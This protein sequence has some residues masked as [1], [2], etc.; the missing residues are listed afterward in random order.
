LLDRLAPSFERRRA[1]LDAS[2]VLFWL[3]GFARTAAEW[4]ETYRQL[5]M[6]IDTAEELGDVA[7]WAH[8]A[9]RKGF[10][11]PDEALLRRSVE[12]AR[13]AGHAGV[14][15][16]TRWN[17]G[18]YLGQQ[19]RYEQALPLIVEAI[20][21]LEA[22][23]T[24][25]DHTWIMAM[26]GRCHSAR[27]G[28]M[29]QALAYATRARAAT[30]AM[31]DPRLRAWCGMEAEPYMYQGRWE[32]VVRVGEEGLRAAWEI[33][34]WA[35]IYFLSAWTGLAYL[36]LG[37]LE[38][39]RRVVSRALRE[40]SA[41]MTPPFIITFL[42]VTLAQ[43]HLQAG[44]H[45]TALAAARRAL[46]LADQS[47][48]RLE[49]GAARRVLGTV[50]AA[51]GHREEADW[52]LRASLEILDEIQCRPELAQTLLAYGRFKVANDTAGGKAMIE[53]AL[54]LFEEMRATGW[55]D[56]TRAALAP[57]PYAPS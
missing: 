41:R 3:P 26:S 50:L 18:E 39:A 46:E 56:E 25:Y 55:I 29:E 27:A 48:F 42:H 33:L 52:E 1:R 57:V 54:G 40:A 37:R 34:E 5:D 9:S 22:A 28:R 10:L 35:P 30:E 38:D 6:A 8:L 49:Q 44:D 45:S 13:A 21:L 12:R 20:G 36:K 24:Q 11:K 23:G 51:A 7:S 43:L 15:A 31:D 19:G 2:L 53:R 14:E 47:R 17:Y 16:H 32:D 4:E